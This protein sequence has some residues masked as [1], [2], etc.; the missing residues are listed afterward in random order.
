MKQTNTPDIWIVYMEKDTNP[1][2]K[3]TQ[4]WVGPW[5][6]I[7]PALLSERSFQGKPNYNAHL[8]VH[9]SSQ[10]IVL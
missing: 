1:V 8:P 5:A 2:P 3:K 6:K 9:S 7:P 10:L 4:R